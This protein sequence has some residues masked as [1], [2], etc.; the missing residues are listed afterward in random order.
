MVLVKLGRGLRLGPCAAAAEAKYDGLRDR[1]AMVGGRLVLVLQYLI[2]YS[3]VLPF[4]GAKVNWGMG[5]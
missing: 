1:L 5:T 4:F 2:L 3:L